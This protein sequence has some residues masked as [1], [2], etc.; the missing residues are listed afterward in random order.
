MGRHQETGREKFFRV[1]API[2]TNVGAGVV[3]IGAM[4]KIMHYPGAGVI[5]PIGL[6]V[7][8]IL[9]FLGA[10]APIPAPEKHYNWENVYPQLLAGEGE[11]VKAVAPTQ[12]NMPALPDAAFETLGDNIKKLNTSV[13]QIQDVSAAATA[14]SE[15]TKTLQTATKSMGDLNKAYSTTLGAMNEMASTAKDAKEYH[16]QIQNIN[17]NLS[18]LN[19]LYDIELKDTNNHL[20]QMNKFYGNLTT[21]MEGMSEASKESEKF[22]SEMTKLTTN[23]TSLNSVYGKMLS[24]MKG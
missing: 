22:K 4:F 13:K 21:A 14:S 8:A 7:E 18:A 5:L 2:L 9:F 12:S 20:K 11:A 1:V 23:L 3:I 6:S 10:V 16:V 17:K 24:A 19:A 15:Y